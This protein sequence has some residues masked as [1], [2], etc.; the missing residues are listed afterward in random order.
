MTFQG[1]VIA[2]DAPGCGARVQAPTNELALGREIVAERFG[3]TSDGHLDH[4]GPC[5][6]RRP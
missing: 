4:C 3:W 2:C 1:I 6:E 5:T